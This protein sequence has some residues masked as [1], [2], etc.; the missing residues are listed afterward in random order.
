[1]LLLHSFSN[2]NKKISPRTSKTHPSKNKSRLSNLSEELSTS[3]CMCFSSDCFIS[4]ILLDKLFCACYYC[5]CLFVSS[6]TPTHSLIHFLSHSC[7]SLPLS[8]SHF[9]PCHLFNLKS[10]FLLIQHVIFSFSHEIFYRMSNLLISN[11][12]LTISSIM[13][14]FLTFIFT[15]ISVILFVFQCCLGLYC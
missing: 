5:I 14:I 10:L 15:I 12:S 6:P 11:L 2:W 13:D 3:F 4:L 9:T 7:L 8:L 1:M